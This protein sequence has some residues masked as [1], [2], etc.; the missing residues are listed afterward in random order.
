M[1]CA[2]KTPFD[3]S[4]DIFWR[5][6]L[7]SILE[8]VS[9]M[10]LFRIPCLEWVRAFKDCYVSS[11]S[12]MPNPLGRLMSDPYLTRYRRQ[13]EWNVPVVNSFD[14]CDE[15]VIN[16]AS[17]PFPPSLPI[18]SFISLAA[19]YYQPSSY[20]PWITFVK[21]VNMMFSAFIPLSRRKHTRCVN[22][23][24]LPAPG[25][26]RIWRMECGGA[27]TA[28]CCARLSSAIA[29]SS[30]LRFAF[31]S[32]PKQARL[33]WSDHVTICRWFPYTC[34]DSCQSI[35]NSAFS[36]K[37]LSA[38]TLHLS[39]ITTAYVIFVMSSPYPYSSM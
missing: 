33:M 9:L 10:I 25:P 23:F 19:F 27:A 30:F 35:A 22:T 11:V 34:R 31:G 3:L 24:V 21:V 29:D 2:A 15:P 8:W 32:W 14:V 16:L 6:S 20:L 37:F 36:K 4:M 18:R 12:A 5:A 17:T 38:H 39:K 7:T 1:L 26:A 28:S 13:I